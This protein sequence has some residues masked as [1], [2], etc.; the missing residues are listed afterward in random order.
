[1]SA[2]DAFSS[3]RTGVNGYGVR[4]PDSRANN[5]ASA[6]R[7]EMRIDLCGQKADSSC[8]ILLLARAVFER[9]PTW[10]KDAAD[11]GSAVEDAGS[12]GSATKRRRSRIACSS[13]RGVRRRVR[14]LPEELDSVGR[15]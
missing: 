4:M 10:L 5:I 15:G 2:I 8:E 1:M 13:K 9:S 12:A 6:V 14:V 7:L 3:A 11:C